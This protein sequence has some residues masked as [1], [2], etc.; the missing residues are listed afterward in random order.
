MHHRH[1]NKKPRITKRKSSQQARQ[2]VSFAFEFTPALEAPSLCSTMGV[3]LSSAKP[4]S[5]RAGPLPFRTP[6]SAFHIPA[7]PTVDQVMTEERAASFTKRSLK[8]SAK[9]AGL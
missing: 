7:V 6:H 4:A 9:L 2:L 1:G 8:T 5:L 3:S